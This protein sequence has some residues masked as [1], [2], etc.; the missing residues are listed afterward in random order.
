MINSM[1]GYGRAVETLGGREYT[2][3][4]KCVNHRFLEPSIKTPR[5]FSFLEQK[6]K[7]T[8][9]KSVGRGKIEVNLSV[10]ERG[11]EET[12]V[13]PNLSAAKG[14]ADAMLEIAKALGLEGK[15]TL[16][17]IARFPDV[18]DVARREIDED[19]VWAD[20]E[21]VMSEAMDSFLSMRAAEGKKL[22]DDIENRLVLIEEQ[23][24]VV[25][26]LAGECQQR[27]QE[28]LAQ[29]LTELLG[30]NYDQS[31]VITEA[32]LLADR[33]AVDEETVRL[34][35]HI[36]QMRGFLRAKEPIGKKMDF[37]VQE[38]NRETNTI[39]SKANNIEI[40]RAVVEMKAQIEKMREQ[41]QNIE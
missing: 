26:S 15:P 3:E 35:S 25:E 34:H 21:K 29:K 27:H 13:A 10:A 4:I 20:C 40:T 9:T 2:V 22:A 17:S 36:D 11:E 32:A 18:F 12:S 31:R 30:Q 16:E 24:A 5:A 41:V 8:L 6:I 33:A 28:R 37:L 1:T 38:F 7:D 19:A 23:L 14:Y 39:G